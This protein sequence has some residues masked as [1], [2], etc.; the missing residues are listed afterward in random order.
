MQ[1]LASF[2]MARPLNAVLVGVVFA[3]L[4]VLIPPLGFLLFTLCAATVALVALRLGSGAALP[5]LIGAI[6]AIAVSSQ[7]LTD[8]A[9][10]SP[11]SGVSS[12]MMMVILP[13]LLVVCGVLRQTRSL[14]ISLLVSAI[15]A[16]LAIV[17]M[18]LFVGDTTVWWQKSFERVIALQPDPDIGSPISEAELD[19][20]VSFLA[21]ASS[22]LVGAIVFLSINLSLFLARWWQAK[23]YNPGGFKEE[24][25]SL[26]FD[27]RITIASLAVLAMTMLFAGLWANLA[28]DLLVIFMAVFTIGGIALVH[29]VVAYK[30]WPRFFVVAQYVLLIF[31]LTAPQMSVLLASLGFADSWL[32]IR[33]RLGITPKRDDLVKRDSEDNDD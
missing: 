22:S 19:N 27:N 24:F 4:A 7:A 12:V 17:S 13:L 32:N 30:N 2:I 18:Y 33:R 10:Q 20:T 21:G 28:K 26:R 5:A 3:V 29:N 1:S 25:H 23:L 14:Q 6:I 11:F 31:P 16:M 15:V 8:T 9:M